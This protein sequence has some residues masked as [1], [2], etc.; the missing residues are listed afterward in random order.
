MQHFRKSSDQYNA[1]IISII[2][3]NTPVNYF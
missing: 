2:L 1:D 3:I